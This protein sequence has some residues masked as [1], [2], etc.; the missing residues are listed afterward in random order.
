MRSLKLSKSTRG[1]LVNL[2]SQMEQ[3]SQT[4]TLQ[5]REVEN[6]QY[7]LRRSEDVANQNNSLLMTRIQHLEAQLLDLTNQLKMFMSYNNK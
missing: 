2:Q 5:R 6:M 1:K 3:V 4:C 7:A